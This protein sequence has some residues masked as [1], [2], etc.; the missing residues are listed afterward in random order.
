MLADSDTMA[1]QTS[2]NYIEHARWIHIYM[3]KFFKVICSIL[4]FFGVFLFLIR[5]LVHLLVL[6]LSC[7]RQA[8]WSA[9]YRHCL[10]I[11]LPLSSDMH[12]HTSIFTPIDKCVYVPSI[13]HLIRCARE[14]YAISNASNSIVEIQNEKEKRIICRNER[15]NLNKLN[16]ICQIPHTNW[17][18]CWCY[19]HDEFPRYYLCMYFGNGDDA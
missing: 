14:L 12:T 19:T 1:L 15:S 3:L 13:Q 2:M 11:V 18:V 4:L 7:R 17:H 5:W 9:S 16:E 8:K 6:L 10:W